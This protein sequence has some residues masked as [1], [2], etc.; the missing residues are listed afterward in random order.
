MPV[1][2]DEQGQRQRANSDHE[3]VPQIDAESR[4][5]HRV[6]DMAEGEMQRNQVVTGGDDLATPARD[7]FMNASTALTP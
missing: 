5:L 4:F 6:D 3:A 1:R 2:N 7:V